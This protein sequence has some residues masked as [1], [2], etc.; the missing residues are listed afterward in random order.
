LTPLEPRLIKKL[1][2]PITS[3]IQTTP[4]TSLLYECIGG[5]ISGGLLAG[6]QDTA[7]GEELASVCVTKLR[8]FLVEGDSN[9]KYV[10][11]IALKKL[12]NTH[13]HL[14]SEHHDVVLSCIDDNDISIRYRA[15][16]LVVGMVNADTLH[17]VVGKL[18]RQLKPTVAK[19]EPELEGAGVSAS[20]DE[21]DMRQGVMH[22]RDAP[23]GEAIALELPDDYKHAVI[24]RILDMC[25]RE[26]YVNVIDFEWYLDVLVQLVRYAP[27]VRADASSGED[28]EWEDSELEELSKKRDVGEA[29]G[30]ELRNVAV[31]VKSVRPEAVR[32]AEM[33]VS[34]RD[35][36][37]PGAGGGGRRV[38][39]AAGW[40]AGEFA[41]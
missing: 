13:A 29:I 6:I 22:P 19:S 41:R 33:L 24:I 3:L 28:G 9:L 34:G 23:K 26:M 4:A 39:G 30:K 7:E 11:L 27:P 8:G 36:V 14:V 20:D 17:V 5:L 25:S 21:D 15:L 1:V 31:R 35:G 12:V 40:I 16:E 2:P 37:F 38:L 32:C 18:M 10:G